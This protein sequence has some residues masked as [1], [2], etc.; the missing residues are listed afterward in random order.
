[1]K[2]AKPKQKNSDK[3]Q[4]QHTSAFNTVKIIFIRTVKM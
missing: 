4:P 3:K 1:M 2:M